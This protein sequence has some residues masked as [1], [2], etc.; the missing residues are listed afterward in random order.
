MQ[1]LYAASKYSCPLLQ[2]V[3]D[4]PEMKNDP[5]KSAN[6]NGTNFIVSS[7]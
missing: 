7:E 1:H 5:T 2:G 4:R 3:G 6:D